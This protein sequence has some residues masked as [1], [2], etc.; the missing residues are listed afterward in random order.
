MNGILAT[1]SAQDLVSGFN[2]DIVSKINTGSILNGN[3][4]VASDVTPLFNTQS[5]PMSN[6]KVTIMTG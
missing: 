3:L 2:T 6:N 4:W 5:G 1:Y